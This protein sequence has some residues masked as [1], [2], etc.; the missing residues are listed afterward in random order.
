MDDAK[1]EL[2]RGWLVKADHDL[3]AAR[4][5]AADPRPFFDTAIYHCQQAAEK[6]L[7]GFLLFQDQPLQR[8]HDLRILANA[9]HA[10]DARFAG[11]LDDADFLTPYATAYRYPAA[12]M[13]PTPQEFND[14][15][16]AAERLCSLVRQSLPADVYP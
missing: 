7:K 2:I 8:T 1:C 9:A 3:G 12:A 5:L 11:C 10:L 15:L 4:K 13:M 14:A 16:A 6:A